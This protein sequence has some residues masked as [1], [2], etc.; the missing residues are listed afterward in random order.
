VVSACARLAEQPS[1]PRVFHCMAPSGRR[2]SRLPMADSIP[3]LGSRLQEKSACTK[4]SPGATMAAL[5]PYR[6]K[7]RV[8][9]KRPDT[10][11]GAFSQV[12]EMSAR[13]LKL[14]VGT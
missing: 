7:A 14:H 5:R 4:V 2:P 3:G 9:G 8:Q 6:R 12:V 1:S 13:D 10:D 11:S